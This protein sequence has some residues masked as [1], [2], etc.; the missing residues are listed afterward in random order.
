MVYVESPTNP[1]LR[2]LDLRALATLAHVRGVTLCVD[3]SAM[4]PYLQQPIALGADI[5]IHSGTKFLSGHSDVTAGAVIVADE[6]LAK[7]TY[8]LQNAEG[9]ALAP[10][11]CFLFLRGLKTLKL[12]MDAQQANTAMIAAYLKSQSKVAS[13]LYPGDL[14]HSGY[15]LQQNQASGAGALIS[16]RLSSSS[17][18]KQFAEGLRLFKIAVSFGSVTSTVSIPAAMSHA[19]VAAEHQTMRSIPGDLLRLSLGIEDAQ[20]LLADLDEQLAR[21]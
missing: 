1:L 14:D 7:E 3:S 20:D 12:R 9:N 21:L 19:S 2:V 4:S 5:V 17:A 10:F 8:F 16:L 18:A 6:A 15:A 11:D 13:V